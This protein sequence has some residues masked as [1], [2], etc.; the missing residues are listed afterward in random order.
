M[1]YSNEQLIRG[2]FAGI[3]ANAN[4][5]KQTDKD[6]L[7]KVAFNV[8][9]LSDSERMNGRNKY[10][11]YLTE[12]DSILNS[13]QQGDY[14][15][16]LSQESVGGVSVEA[17]KVEFTEVQRRAA[18]VAGLIAMDSKAYA[19][20]LMSAAARAS[21]D[22][23]NVVAN[24][25]GFGSDIVDPYTVAETIN[26]ETFSGQAL[27]SVYYTTVS[28]AVAGSRQDD[29][30]DA[31]FPL[32]IVGPTDSFYETKIEIQSYMA[33]TRHRSPYATK[34]PFDKK[35]ILKNI[36]N[37]E[38]LSANRLEIKPVVAN[39]TA[40]DLLI[41]EAKYN[42]TVADET[43]ETAPYRVDQPI[44]LFAIC[45]TTGEVARGSINDMTDTIDRAVNLRALYLG[46]E[47]AAHKKLQVKIDTTYHQR[48]TFNVQPEGYGKELKL[49]Y[50]GLF[51]VSTKNS[52][53]FQNKESSDNLLFGATIGAL[54]EHIVYL[55]TIVNG[56]LIVNEGAVNVTA[57]KLKVE[58]IVNAVTKAEVTD[59]RSGVGQQIV[60]KV[61][62]FN[63]AGYDIDPKITNENFRRR[64]LLITSDPFKYRQNVH[65]RSGVSVIK[66][67]ES[68][69][70]NENDG[71]IITVDIQAGALND[72]MAS[73]AVITF[74]DFADRLHAAADANALPDFKTNTP[75]EQYIY[76]WYKYER[77]KVQD[78]A[79]SMRSTERREDVSASIFNKIRDGVSI[80]GIES[81][82]DVVFKK[83]YRGM[84]KTIVIATDPYIASYLSE[85]L[86]Q[87]NNGAVTANRFPLTYDTDAMI[88]STQNPLMKG[89]LM[90]TYSLFDDPK[91]N[92]EPNAM[93]FGWGLFT[94]P[95]NREIRYTQ[96]GA[97]YDTLFAEPRYTYV[98]NL[99]IML[100]YKVEGVTEAMAKNVQH[101]HI[102]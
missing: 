23:A 41:H 91:R 99:P 34:N 13:I 97:T 36:F 74:V 100:E 32:I 45:N 71:Y 22:T 17:P 59:F 85:Q 73:N 96:N 68:Q 98:P 47:N 25:E 94:P 15:S 52:K 49:H 54:Q 44:N 48:T 33:E 61:A 56:T 63:V 62:E 101:H 89:R 29:F 51:T 8:E 27:N 2:V 66:P 57:T 92:Q 35:P 67:A 43:Y 82:Y 38:L 9:G 1:S 50:R 21:H 58:K 75:S 42:T 87:S 77:V 79:D 10:N 20:G 7:L 88:V 4:I 18:E 80:M 16:T 28:L 26:Q 93:S 81:Y 14:I 95:L 64:G 84:K 3:A 37:N 72:M 65:F 86:I 90:I 70:G 60:N 30:T 46:Y 31:L 39:D 53:D 24:F 11:A 78:L 19:K 69:M 102:V 76:P 55:S 83:L 12:I 6:S 40:Q 5:V